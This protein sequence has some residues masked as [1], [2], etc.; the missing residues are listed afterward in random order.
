[1]ISVKKNSCPFFY[2]KLCGCCKI[3]INVLFKP[4]LGCHLEFC[5]GYSDS[6]NVSHMF[7]LSEKNWSLFF[8]KRSRY[9]NN[10]WD[11]EGKSSLIIW[12]QK[13]KLH[14]P[15]IECLMFQR[16]KLILTASTKLLFVSG[17]RILFFTL[18]GTLAP[19][20]TTSSLSSSK[21]FDFSYWFWYFL[22]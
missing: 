9:G 5:V 18:G 3:L 8:I 19:L 22:C 10:W 2:Q 21:G 4:G 12:D 16:Y 14:G 6:F 7:C 11:V 20:S 13:G 17:Q 1:M 15:L